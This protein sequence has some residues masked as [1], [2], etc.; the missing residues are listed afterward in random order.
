ME[1]W[2]KRAAPAPSGRRSHP[3]RPAALGSG[4]GAMRFCPPA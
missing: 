4:G 2:R 1:G 3:P